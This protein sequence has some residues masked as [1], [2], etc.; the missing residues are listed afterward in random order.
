MF[1]AREQKHL[2]NY[3]WNFL[4]LMNTGNEPRNLFLHQALADYFQQCKTICRF[5]DGNQIS[6]KWGFGS[7]PRN[8]WMAPAADSNRAN[9]LATLLLDALRL[10]SQQLNNIIALED[11]E[12]RGWSQG[13]VVALQNLQKQVLAFREA[14]I[15]IKELKEQIGEDVPIGVQWG[16]WCRHAVEWDWSID[17]IPVPD[18]GSPKRT[19]D[20]DEV[21]AAKNQV[22]LL[23]AMFEARVQNQSDDYQTRFLALVKDVNQNDMRSIQQVFET[24][25]M[26]WKEMSWA[27]S[28]DNIRWTWEVNV[29]RILTT[30]QPHRAFEGNDE[31][32]KKILGVLQEHT[33]KYK[34]IQDEIKAK[35]R[36]MRR[37]AEEETLGVSTPSSGNGRLKLSGNRGS[38]LE[39]IVLVHRCLLLGNRRTSGR[40]D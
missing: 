21:K 5:V 15:Q 17:I 29:H 27:G 26:Q 3:G 13:A 18:S 23:I 32:Y 2:F 16:P 8:N 20:L 6:C 25:W 40:S 28:G 19:P 12:K 39:S 31:D 24:G 22:T 10:I 9:G 33:L 4:S 38:I 1:E 11:A 14:M 36:S 34:K 35:E 30:G 7:S 37:G